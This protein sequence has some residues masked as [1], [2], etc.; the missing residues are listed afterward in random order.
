[1]SVSDTPFEMIGGS[2]GR[3][4]YALVRRA[5]E[6]AALA[7]L[8]DWQPVRHVG[9]VSRLGALLQEPV[10]FAAA[11]LAGLAGVRRYHLR[12]SGRPVLMRHGTVD[13][14][15]F[16][17]IFA[18]RLYEPPPAVE[19]E[20]RALSAPLVLDIGANIGMFG[21]DLLSRHPGA[22]IIAYEPDAENAAIHRRLVEINAAGDDW[23]LLEACA[24]PRDDV[25]VFLPGQETGSRVVGSR[26]PGSVDVPM[27]D[28]MP[29]F[30]RADLVKIDIE[31]GEWEL[32]GD[33]RFAAAR[34]VVMEYHPDGCPGDDPAATAHELLRGHGFT[35]TP[36]LEQPDGV[37]MLWA[38]R[39]HE[40]T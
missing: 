13:T 22:R 3:D 4:R 35:I 32:L 29:L 9:S 2:V 28:V 21:L 33:P 10:R 14:W 6:V 7:A 24:G 34:N 40:V 39:D 17:E 31:G 12:S 19:A 30:A 18:L 37:G 23:Q 16:S 11:D 1:M 25:V 20:L 5:R 8:L 38:T 26:A 27:I 36:V 15:T